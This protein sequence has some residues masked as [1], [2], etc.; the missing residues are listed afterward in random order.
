MKGRT[1]LMKLKEKSSMFHHHVLLY[2][3]VLMEDVIGKVG[4][5][6]DI[7]RVNQGGK[8]VFTK[9]LSRRYNEMLI[10]SVNMAPRSKTLKSMINELFTCT[11]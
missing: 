9:C 8:Y 5:I 1:P 10:F 2:P 6:T 4:I 7:L 11:R 3:V